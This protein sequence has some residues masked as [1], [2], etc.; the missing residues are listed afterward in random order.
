MSKTGAHLRIQNFGTNCQGVELFG[1]PKRPEPLTFLVKLPTAE[2]EIS[3]TTDGRY[4]VH[5]TK[6]VNEENHSI[7]TSKFDDVRMD[8][9][10]EHTSKINLGDFKDPNIYH[11]AVLTSKI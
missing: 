4:W 1:D 5:I 10:T 11:L 7:R 6:T 2:V 8:S 3:R 9:T